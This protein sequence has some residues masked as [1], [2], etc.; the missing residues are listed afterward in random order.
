MMPPTLGD[1]IGNVCLSHLSPNGRKAVSAMARQKKGVTRTISEINH[2]MRG[3]SKNAKD[4]EEFL[5]GKKEYAQSQCEKD[6]E[7]LCI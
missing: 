6:F 5:R 4:R 3:L 7:A 2:F 1:Q